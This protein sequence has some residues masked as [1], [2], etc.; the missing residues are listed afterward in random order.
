M[1]KEYATRDVLIPE[2]IDNKA[3]YI[4]FIPKSIIT[5]NDL[6]TDIK[7]PTNVYIETNQ[8]HDIAISK[9]QILNKELQSGSIHNIKAKQDIYDYL[10]YIIL[11]IISFYTI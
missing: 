3:Y 5:E 11:L 6:M 10:L 8:L 7:H 4:D 1:C 9:N 2:K